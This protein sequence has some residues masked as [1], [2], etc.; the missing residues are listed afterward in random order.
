MLMV[1]DIGN[2][3]IKIGVVDLSSSEKFNLITGFRLT[4][5]NNLTSDELGI[6]VKGILRDNSV[7]INPYKIKA[8]IC[9][10]VV[11]KLN[12][13]FSNMSNRYLEHTPYFI[14]H[15]SNLG[16]KISYKHPSEIGADRLVNAVAV[17]EIYKAPAIIIDFGTATTFC[18]LSKKKGYMGGVIVPGVLISQD[19][20]SSSAAKLPQIELVKPNK[21]LGTST[22][23]SMASGAYYSAIGTIEKIYSLI[24]KEMNENNIKVIATGGLSNFIGQGT[25]VIDI[26]DPLLTVKGMKAIYEKNL[27]KFDN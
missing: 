25:K 6:W 27:D 10:S 9:A 24:K 1:I 15:K 17:N 12:H 14:S 23:R 21:A 13:T 16:M 7:R 22:K 3:N 4:T 11:P 8:I 26:V 2:T 19:A 5:K 18:A 20:L